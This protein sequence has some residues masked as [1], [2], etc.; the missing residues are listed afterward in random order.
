MINLNNIKLVVSDLDGTLL[1]SFGK[2][3]QEDIETLFE[4]GRQGVVRAIATGRSPYSFDKVIPADFPIDYLIFS[5][6][7]GTL[8]WKKRKI[9]YTT[10]LLPDEVQG[11]ADILIQNEVDFMV[12]EP[13]PANHRFLYHQASTNNSD[14]IRRI[15]IYHQ[16][17]QPYIPGIAYGSSATQILAVL[18]KNVE[19]FEKLKSLFPAMKV[20]RA[21]SPLDGHSIWMEIFRKDV[22]KAHGVGYLCGLLK[23]QNNQ[24]LTIGNDFNDLDMLSN[25]EVSFVVSNAPEELKEQFPSVKS[26]NESGFSDAVRR[27]FKW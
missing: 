2:V 13:I 11:V 16:Y 25:F 24:V 21:T 22:S 9:H 3:S 26:N 20:I 19:L 14:F 10:E 1:N 27:M 23:I 6:G 4:L 15:E 5:S 8:E 12:H 17:C 18:P 7:A